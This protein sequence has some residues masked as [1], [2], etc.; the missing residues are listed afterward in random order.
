MKVVSNTNI[1]KRSEN[2]DRVYTSVLDDGSV[3][4]IL[5]DGMG[6]ENAGG[7]AAETAVNIIK[8]RILFGYSENYDSN[9][10]RN[11]LISSVSAANAAVFAAAAED[12]SKKGMGTTCVIA[13]V[14]NG[15]AQIV[16]V[17]DSRAYFITK[18]GMEQITKDH[19]VVRFLYEK[20]EISKEEIPTHPQRNY[21]TRAVGASSVVDID[22]FE[23][24][25]VDNG[26]LLLCSD[27]LSSYCTDDEIFCVVNNGNI[28]ENAERLIELALPKSRDNITLALIGNL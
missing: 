20:G 22:Y 18:D 21:I 28:E 8:K 19:T 1:G 11:I 16:N 5:C 10:I 27:G 14:R 2:Q 23:K 9:S 26:K 6:G 15:V 3:I 12:E 7:F 4:A 13:F 24:N 17:G 25:I